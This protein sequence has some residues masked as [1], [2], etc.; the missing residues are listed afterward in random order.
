VISALGL[1]HSV[2]WLAGSDVLLASLYAHAQALIFPSLYEGFGLPPLEAMHYGCPVV[3][4]NSSSLPEVVDDA[5]VTVDT[6]DPGALAGGIATAV[7]DPI[8]RAQLISAGKVREA[9]FTW[10]RTA[11]LTVES[12]RKLIS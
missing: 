10:D 5:A 3:C 9:T 2:V 7:G 11:T 1:S 12:Y 4:S 8:L 6:G